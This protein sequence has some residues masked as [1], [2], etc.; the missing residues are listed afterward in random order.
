MGN[1]TIHL[2]IHLSILASTFYPIT[3]SHLK[4]INV[5]AQIMILS[6]I[7]D[8]SQITEE[9]WLQYAFKLSRW[10]WRISLLISFP[11]LAGVQ[12]RGNQDKLVGKVWE[13]ISKVV[14]RGLFTGPLVSTT[15]NLTPQ[16]MQLRVEQN[17]KK[18]S[19]VCFCFCSFL[20]V[21]V[22][23]CFCLFL[24]LVVSVSVCF[25][26]QIQSNKLQPCWGQLWPAI[27]V[28]R[29]HN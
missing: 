23:I 20:F 4:D 6:V 29:N 19:E 11:L 22:S 12:I 5:S 25:C 1:L 17:E 24:F 18:L 3:S 2:L 8:D 27:A 16:N 13:E 28:K 21:S 10:I 9:Y 14:Q 26:L 7:H 15:P